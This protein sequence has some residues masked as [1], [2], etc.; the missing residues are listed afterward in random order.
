MNI[1]G[2]KNIQQFAT[3]YIYSFHGH[4]QFVIQFLYDFAIKT[5]SDGIGAPKY[6]VSFFVETVKTA[7][8][9]HNHYQQP[10]QCRKQNEKIPL[11]LRLN[12]TYILRD[13]ENDA[14]TE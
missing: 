10:I 3:F 8:I 6:S 13:T 9:N 12:F 2:R 1:F 4:Q 11:K 7:L 5:S 14:T